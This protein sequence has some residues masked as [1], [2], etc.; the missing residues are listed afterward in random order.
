ML[1]TVLLILIILV[2][3]NFF[4][5]RFSCNKTTKKSVVEAPMVKA[6]KNQVI[7]TNQSSQNRLA[8]TGS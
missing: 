7:K 6:C 5:L 4:L 3:F 8:P 1:L 2:G